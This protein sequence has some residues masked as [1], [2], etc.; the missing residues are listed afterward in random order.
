M[1][2][3]DDINATVRRKLFTDVAAK[4]KVTQVFNSLASERNGVENVAFTLE[5]WGMLSPGKEVRR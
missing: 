4:S 5:I 3:Q 1:Y 2:R